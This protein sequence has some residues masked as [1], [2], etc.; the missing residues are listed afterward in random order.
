MVI[1]VKGETN[2]QKAQ[3][4]FML[5]EGWEEHKEKG[6]VGK[7]RRNFYGAFNNKFSH[8]DARIRLYLTTERERE[9]EE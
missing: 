3:R 8:S 7:K 4:N 6:K 5:G 2:A 9:R 1:K